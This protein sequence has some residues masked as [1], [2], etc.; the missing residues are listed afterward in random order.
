MRG[1]RHNLF[2]NKYGRLEV[3]GF[4]SLKT[5]NRSYLWPCKCEC[6]RT[7]Y[8]TCTQL[9]NGEVKECRVC[10]NTYIRTNKYAQ[11]KRMFEDATLPLSAM[12]E[13]G[14]EEL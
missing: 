10:A 14:L 5:K 6:G 2:G 7:R 12:E 13:L 4:P 1:A 3:V 9:M 11:N 8:V